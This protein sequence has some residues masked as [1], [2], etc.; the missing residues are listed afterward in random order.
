[1]DTGVILGIAATLIVG[2]VLW[3]WKKEDIESFFNKISPNRKIIAYFEEYQKT[4]LG[5][6]YITNNKI[7]PVRIK[8]AYASMKDLVKN[9]MTKELDSDIY[10][11]YLFS[12]LTGAEKRI[13]AISI[14]ADEEWVVNKKE[15]PD[16]LVRDIGSGFLAFDDYAIAEDVFADDEIR[17]SLLTDKR[18]I[19][20]YEHYFT[21]LKVHA[22]EINADFLDE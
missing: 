11:L 19:K 6:Q 16:D 21:M 1:M 12:L 8:K 17:G 20:R 7:N 3:W 5:K 13:W 10:Y 18:T 4:D 9:K 22:K 14:M 2:L 15:V